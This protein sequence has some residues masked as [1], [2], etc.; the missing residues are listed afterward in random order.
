MT[1]TFIKT[2]ANGEMIFANDDTLEFFTVSKN[3]ESATVN[4]ASFKVIE[5]MSL[6]NGKHKFELEAKNE[7]VSESFLTE[8]ETV[9]LKC[10]DSVME[11]GNVFGWYVVDNAPYT[12]Q[13]CGGLFSS[14]EKKG[15]IEVTGYN[16][17]SHSIEITV[18]GENYLNEELSNN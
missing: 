8:K 1:A 18:E 13:A 3:F 12:A 9:M 10:I 4:E 11:M 16:S 14:L 5:R 17:D 15:M 7:D 2:N 6:K